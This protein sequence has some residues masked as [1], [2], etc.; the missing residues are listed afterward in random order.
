MINKISYI[1][2]DCIAVLGIY[3]TVRAVEKNIKESFGAWLNKAMV[4]AIFAI[5]A[6]ILVALSFSFFSAQIAYCLYFMSIDWIIYFLVGFCLL[7]TEHEKAL[8]LMYVPAAVVMSI[9]SLSILLNPVFGH[10]FYTY[11]KHDSLGVLFYQTRFFAPYYIHLAID[12]IAI[13]IALF[14]IVFRLVKS[15]SVYRVKYVII[16]SVLLLVVFL[17]VVYMELKL[18]MD[19]SV[20][21][22]AVAGILIY[23]SIQILVPRNLKMSS[24]ERAIDDMNEGLILFD[25]GNTCIYANDF[26]KR[27]FDIEESSYDIT[28]EPAATV[29]ENL[30]S[31]DSAFGEV[32]YTRNVSIDNA[33]VTEHYIIKCSPLNDHKGRIIGSYFLIEDNTEQE[34]YLNEIRA[35]KELADEANRAKSNFL[36]NM[37]HEIRTPLN[38][39]LGLNEMILRTATDPQLKEYAENIRISGDALL[40]L[41]SDI[42]D[43]SK[44]EAKKMDVVPVEYDPH[45]L[46]RESN[47]FFEQMADSKDLIIEVTCDESVPSRLCG[48]VKLIKQ[49]MTNIISNAIKY[50]R[51]GGVRVHM[52]HRP[53]GSNDKDVTDLVLTVS[54]TGIGI[55]K[56]DIDVLFDAFKRI[57]E[58]EN[59]TIQGTG[60][61]LAITRELVTLMNG[62][63]SVESTPGKGSTFTIIL[64]QKVIDPTPAGKYKKHVASEVKQYTESFTAPDVRLLI[65]DD[66]RL[67]LKVVQALLKSTGMQT[68][69]AS[70]GQQAIDMCKEK[71]YDLILLDHR[72]PEPDGIE[73]FKVISKEGLNKDTPVIMLTANVVSG[74]EE[75]YKKIGFVDYLSKPIHGEDLEAALVRHLPPEKVIYSDPTS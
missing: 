15:Y 50:T 45:H 52:S 61:G 66:A 59:A 51:E 29:L 46:L 54:D 14:F 74:A 35:A 18:P 60:L 39:V 71:K 9:D 23:F 38:S 73:T 58:K 42:L 26:S 4:T 72:M 57:N 41:I 43:F 5:Y 75:E 16:L 37:S 53:S 17:N 70:G 56:A 49:I 2:V 34:F 55:S 65:V 62:T 13:L 21:F 27:R 31:A 20:V 1:L 10:E 48:D 12:Y 69:T 6:N 63:I 25:I 30:K 32:A 11:A 22:Y 33:D 28:K 7:Y 68:D 24:I 8:K 67:N 64:P 47:S 19:V 40:S 36:A 44:I 3:F